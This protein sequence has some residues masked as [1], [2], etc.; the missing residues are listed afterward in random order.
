MVGGCVCNVV[1]PGSLCIDL[2]LVNLDLRLGI[3]VILGKDLFEIGHRLADIAV[4][5]ARGVD[6]GRSRIGG[7]DRLCLDRS[8]VSGA[9]GE[10]DLNIL[11]ALNAPVGLVY[12]FCRDLGHIRN[13]GHKLYRLAV[14]AGA[15]LAVDA[16]GSGGNGVLYHNADVDLLVA[17]CENHR[18]CAETGALERLAF[19][20]VSGI[21]AAECREHVAFRDHIHRRLKLGYRVADDD[22]ARF[23]RAVSGLIGGLY[24]AGDRSGLRQDRLGGEF[25]AHS[26]RVATAQGEVLGLYLAADEHRRRNDVR[27]GSR[28]IDYAQGRGKGLSVKLG[29]DLVVAELIPCDV[30]KIG[31][32]LCILALYG[33]EVLK[34]RARLTGLVL[35]DIDK[36]ENLD[37]ELDAAAVSAGIFKLYAAIICSGSAVGRLL[38]PRCGDL[39]RILYLAQSRL[40]L[41]RF[42]IDGYLGLGGIGRRS[43][44]IAYDKKLRANLAAAFDL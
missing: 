20:L 19:H 27:V 9:V 30:V 15:A 40:G 21:V 39:R 5:V 10:H 12:E 23:L 13:I 4:S 18:V 25:I 11:L 28:C 26:G 24:S 42:I 7:Y 32:E 35:K 22:L 41:E 3:C 6:N 44:R 17:F 1:G 33:H 2:G 8:L 38:L 36:T 43:L 14:V 31:H 16:L 37:R 29:L 34:A